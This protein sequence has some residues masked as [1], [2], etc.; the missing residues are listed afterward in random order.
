MTELQ[1]GGHTVSRPERVTEPL[2]DIIEVFWRATDGVH[3]YELAK[4]TKRGRPTVYNNLD[5]LSTLGWITSGWED[6]TQVRGRPLR[7]IYRLSPEG[8]KLAEK[9]LVES[10]RIAREDFGAVADGSDA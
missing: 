3:G 6:S 5:R 1:E 9:L 4:K 7:R 10:G 8:Q 2:L